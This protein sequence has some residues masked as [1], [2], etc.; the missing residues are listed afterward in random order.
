MH[1]EVSLIEGLL[2][3]VGVVLLYYMGT[4]GIVVLTRPYAGRWYRRALVSLSFAVLFAPSLAGVGHGA[5]VPV[6]AWV[7]ALDTASRWRGGDFLTWGLLPIAVT[8][9]VFFGLASL[10]HMSNNNKKNK[11]DNHGREE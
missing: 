4:R 8:W 6:P 7:T 11:V 10:A 3:T 5:V 9:V 2:R 1:E